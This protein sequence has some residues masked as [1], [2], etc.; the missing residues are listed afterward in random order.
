MQRHR[1]RRK[2]KVTFMPTR[3]PGRR[4]EMKPLGSSDSVFRGDNLHSDT[5]TKQAAV[6]KLNGLLGES[7]TGIVPES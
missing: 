4:G 3:I 2:L 6:G 5:R 1:C 7:P